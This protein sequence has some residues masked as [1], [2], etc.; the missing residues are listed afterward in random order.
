MNAAAVEAQALA[1]GLAATKDEI[2]DADKV[3]A[4]YALILEQTTTAQGDFAADI[5]DRAR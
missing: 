2:T 5:S 3:A 4:R 1:M